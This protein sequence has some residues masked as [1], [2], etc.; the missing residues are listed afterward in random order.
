VHLSDRKSLRESKS[1]TGPL[2]GCS[3]QEDNSQVRITK[4]PGDSVKFPMVLQKPHFGRIVG[5][6]C[7]SIS[8]DGVQFYFSEPA[9]ADH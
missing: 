9:T 6:A 1:M 5:L 4:S 7:V 3:E 2:I 8:V